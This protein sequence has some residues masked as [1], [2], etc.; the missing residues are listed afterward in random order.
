[1]FSSLFQCGPGS[2]SNQRHRS[3]LLCLP[4]QHGTAHS[5]D[6]HS[7]FHLA[8]DSRSCATAWPRSVCKCCFSQHDRYGSSGDY[9]LQ[10]R[11]PERQHSAGEWFP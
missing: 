7:Q 2:A 10:H 1:M 3:M 11:R 6:A 4:G 5:G 8:A 9:E